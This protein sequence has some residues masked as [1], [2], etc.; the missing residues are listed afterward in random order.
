MLKLYINSILIA[1]G[2]K[3]I[4]MWEV[5][6][7]AYKKKK[8]LFIYDS[9]QTNIQFSKNGEYFMLNGTDPKIVYIYNARNLTEV[10]KVTLAAKDTYGNDISY[11]SMSNLSF[12]GSYI[13]ASDY[14]TKEIKIRITKNKHHWLSLNF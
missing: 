5:T 10:S 3:I 11:F 4:T 2:K 7:Q 13:L 8:E 12:D 9:I 1:L 14:T 6:S